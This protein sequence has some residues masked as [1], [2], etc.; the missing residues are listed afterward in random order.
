MPVYFYITMFLCGKSLHRLI[1]DPASFIFLERQT[2]CP[3]KIIGCFFYFGS[4]G[5]IMAGDDTACFYFRKP[6]LYIFQHILIIMSRIDK[7]KIQAVVFVEMRCFRGM[8]SQWSGRVRS[9]E[10]FQPLVNVTTMAHADDDHA[11]LLTADLVDNPVGVR[12]PDSPPPGMAVE[13]NCVCEGIFFNAG[14]G[15]HGRT[16][17]IIRK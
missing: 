5:I 2:R 17:E 14:D 9:I 6:C 7:N 4:P 8:F 16:P 10:R 11:P 12:K 1:N 15:L 13:F 3:K